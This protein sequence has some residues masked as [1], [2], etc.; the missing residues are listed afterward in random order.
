M[1]VPKDHINILPDRE[2]DLFRGRSSSYDVIANMWDNFS[3]DEYVPY[4]TF[5]KAKK[6]NDWS[7]TI[8]IPEPFQMTKRDEMKAKRK[9]KR[10]EQIEHDLHMKQL[11]E[12]A[13]LQKRVIPTPIPP[14]T[15]LP[16]YDELTAHQEKKRAYVRD[17]SKQILKCT[18][19]P[20]KFIKREEAKKDLKR[21]VSLN[22]LFKK[23]KEDKKNKQFKASPY[24][25]KLFDLTLADKQAEEEEYRRIKIKLRSQEM[26]ASSSLPAN[27][28]T[29]NMKYY[30][31]RAKTRQVKEELRKR[32]E[33]SFQP[34]I[35]Y[36]IPDFETLQK[37]VDIELEERKNN[38]IPTV[39]EPFDLHTA[40]VPKRRSE[41]R[42]S[43][44]RNKIIERPPSGRPHSRGRLTD[45]TT[46]SPQLCRSYSATRSAESPV[47]R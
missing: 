34:A 14:S 12:E 9:S 1:Q 30:P 42:K 7:P 25:D 11:Q 2:E 26:L 16:L 3:V 18:E 24:P 10:V 37:K 40:N 35:H 41:F 29:R 36:H 32:K 4:A 13:E 38:N 47:F 15:F 17:L 27:M 6:K 19:K 20:F 33:K 43:V 21:S 8:T 28:R 45:K 23:Q 39:A 22:S 5:K 31:A 46:D 44:E